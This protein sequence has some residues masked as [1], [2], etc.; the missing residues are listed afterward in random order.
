VQ[1]GVLRRQLLRLIHVKEFSP[2]AEFKVGVW[3]GG[4]GSGRGWRLVSRNSNT[5][6]LD[7]ACTE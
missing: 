2:E 7:N 1:V 6:I 3:V 5:N 4:K